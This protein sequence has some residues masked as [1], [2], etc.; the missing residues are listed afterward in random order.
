MEPHWAVLEKL[1]EGSDRQIDA[2]MVKKLKALK[3]KTTDEVKTGLHEILD[4]SAHGALASDFVMRVLD[5]E[6]QRLGG[7]LTD[8]APW[9]EKL[10]L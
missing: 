4:L 3:G 8:P 2:S 9:Q 6:W 5:Y 10:S 7:K 1:A